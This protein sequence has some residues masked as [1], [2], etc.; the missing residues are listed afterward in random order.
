MMKITRWGGRY[1]LPSLLSLAIVVSVLHEIFSQ[2]LALVDFRESY[3][4]DDIELLKKG[5]KGSISCAVASF[6]GFYGLCL[7]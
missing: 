1:T 4:V 5:L 6:Y 7:K 3:F 2:F